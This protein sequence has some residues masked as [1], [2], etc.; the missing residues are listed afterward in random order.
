M[1]TDSLLSRNLCA[2]DLPVTLNYTGLEPGSHNFTII[3]TSTTGQVSE[4]FF[5]FN[6]LERLSKYIINSMAECA[7]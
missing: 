6:V 4:Q 2:G 5:N 7:S 3:A 1:C